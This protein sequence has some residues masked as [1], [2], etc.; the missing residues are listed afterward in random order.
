MA[1]QNRAAAQLAL[2]EYEEAAASYREALRHQAE[3]EEARQGLPFALNLAGRP[4][5]AVRAADDLLRSAPASGRVRLHR[6]L[7]LA[8]LGRTAAAREALAGLAAEC[9]DPEVRKVA[10]LYRDA[11]GTPE[12]RRLLEVYRGSGGR[13]TR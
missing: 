3:N 10:A 11:L 9:P 1:M 6:G 4:Q 13:A 12:E 7:A 2:G 8:L 5:D